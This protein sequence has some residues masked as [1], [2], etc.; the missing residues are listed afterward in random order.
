MRAATALVAV[1]GSR[2]ACGG[3]GWWGGSGERVHQ[4]LLPLSLQL[5][6]AEI[7]PSGVQ[8]GPALDG[9]SW[10]L[11]KTGIA[12]WCLISRGNEQ[13]N[14]RCSRWLPSMCAPPPCQLTAWLMTQPSARGNA[15]TTHCTHV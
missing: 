7:S 15:N 6:Y 4:S 1:L 14:E 13:L 10:V 12:W 11:V 2:A 8:P 3:G 5:K 9:H